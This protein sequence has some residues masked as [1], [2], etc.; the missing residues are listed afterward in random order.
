MTKRP[1]SSLPKQ[2]TGRRGLS[3]PRTSKKQTRSDPAPALPKTGPA[4]MPTGR[5]LVRR[6]WTYP[7]P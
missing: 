5:E 2:P 4:V 1:M 3:Q 6:L 7:A